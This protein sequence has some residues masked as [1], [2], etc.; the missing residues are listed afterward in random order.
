MALSGKK[1]FLITRFFKWLVISLSIICV[2]ENILTTLN[3]IFQQTTNQKTPTNMYFSD[4]LYNVDIHNLI[5][6]VK[7]HYY[8]CQLLNSVSYYNIVVF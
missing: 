7:D 6:L 1:T 8:D 3:G 2:L 4:F 5:L